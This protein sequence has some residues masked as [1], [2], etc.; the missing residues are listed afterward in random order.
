MT[1]ARFCIS[2]QSAGTLPPLTPSQSVGSTPKADVTQKPSADADDVSSASLL[3][4]PGIK[5]ISFDWH[6]GHFFVLFDLLSA[7]VGHA[8]FGR[9]GTIPIGLNV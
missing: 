6:F 1:S 5:T 4:L 2:R 9:R 3:A 7:I 8:E